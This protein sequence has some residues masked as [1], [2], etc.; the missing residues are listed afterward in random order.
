MG[1]AKKKECEKCRESMRSD[2]LGRHQE[3]CGT[4]RKHGGARKK[5]A[6]KA[7]LAKAKR[8]VKKLVVFGVLGFWG[9]GVLAFLNLVVH[10]D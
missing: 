10:L 8:V 1:K 2:N 7:K 6:I 3:T 9:F 4:D 5:K